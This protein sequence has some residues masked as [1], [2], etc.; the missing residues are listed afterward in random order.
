[1]C[2]VRFLKCF[3]YRSCNLKQWW[4][5]KDN[6]SSLKS[7]ARNKTR[8]GWAPRQKLNCQIDFFKSFKLFVVTFPT[9]SCFDDNRTVFSDVWLAVLA[10]ALWFL[11]ISLL[12]LQHATGTCCDTIK[13]LWWWTVKQQKWYQDQS[14]NQ[15][16]ILSLNQTF[17]SQLYSASS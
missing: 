2:F 13:S 8:K 6:E 12:I 14:W 17:R 15:N 3:H 4:S 10:V 9:F 5:M 7:L 16:S 1:M 11:R